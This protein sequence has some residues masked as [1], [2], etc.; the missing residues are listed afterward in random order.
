MKVKPDLPVFMK[1]N[2]TVTVE[3]GGSIIELQD[4]TKEDI[5]KHMPDDLTDMEIAGF[6]HR[7]SHGKVI[8]EEKWGNEPMTMNRIVRLINVI[9]ANKENIKHR[10][11]YLRILE[12]WRNSDFSSVDYDHNSVWEIQHGTVGRATGILSHEEEMK[13]IQQYYDLKE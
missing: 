3:S 13:Y 8:A 7:M 2:A 10:G 6:L 5:E 4:D 12:K 11:T 1:T 9:E